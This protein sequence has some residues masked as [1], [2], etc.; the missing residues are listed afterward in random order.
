MDEAD[1]LDADRVI[2]HNQVEGESEIWQNC[3]LINMVIFVYNVK[4]SCLFLKSFILDSLQAV[5]QR[6]A[7]GLDSGKNT[8][9]Y[10]SQL[11]PFLRPQ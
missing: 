4:I 11:T 8:G 10:N 5:H 1:S 3:H 6:S 7:I 9:S 2:P